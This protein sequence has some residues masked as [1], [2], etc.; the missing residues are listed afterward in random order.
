MYIQGAE[1]DRRAVLLEPAPLPD[2]GEDRGVG[3]G[4]KTT[5]A[6][7]RGVWQVYDREADEDHPRQRVHA[8]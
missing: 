4:D 5:S 6:R 2:R 8:A 7:S 1:N 3:E